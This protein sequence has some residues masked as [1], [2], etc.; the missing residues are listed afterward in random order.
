[1]E[2]QSKKYKEIIIFL[3]NQFLNSQNPDDIAD[4]EIEDEDQSLDSQEE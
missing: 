3:F 2:K 4:Q 1:M